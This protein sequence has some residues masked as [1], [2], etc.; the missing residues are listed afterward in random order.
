M[1]VQRQIRIDDAG[2]WIYRPER[3]LEHPVLDLEIVFILDGELKFRSG[4]RTWNLKQPDVLLFNPPLTGLQLMTAPTL[5]ISPLKEDCFFI[6]L[7]V[8]PPFLA[9]AFDGVIPVFECDSTFQEKD[10][11]VLRGI[12]AEIASGSITASQ[13]LLFYSRLYR[14]LDELGSHFTPSLSA[15]DDEDGKRRRSIQAYIGKHYHSPLGLEDL[16]AYL[17]LSPQYLSRYFKKLYGVNF[18]AYLQRFR[19][20]KALYDLAATDK[21]VAA[22]AY[23]NGFPNL[24]A[25]NRE[26]KEMLGQTPTEYR[27]KQGI[28]QVNLDRA[29]V[30]ALEIESRLVQDRL[31]PFIEKKA[32][33][34]RKTLSVD[35]RSG[36]P[37]EKPWQEVINLGFATDFEKSEFIAQ[38]A[39][40]QREAPFRYARFQGIFGKSMLVSNGTEYGFSRIDRIIDFLSSVN[41]IP[42]IEIGFKPNKITRDTAS[43]LFNNDNEMRNILID[44]FEKLFIKFLKHAITRYGVQEVNRWRFEWWVPTD[45]KNNIADEQIKDY[46]E[47]FVRIRKV[48]KNLVPAALIGG[49]GIVA[50]KIST[51]GAFG[52]I[53]RALRLK[54]S[55]PDFISFYLFGCSH[56]EEKDKP[57]LWEKDEIPKRIKWVKQCVAALHV[58]RPEIPN[59]MFFVTEW[60]IDYSSRN[61]IH[62]SLLKAPYILQNAIHSIDYVGALSYWLLSDISTEYTDSDALLFGGAGLV[63]RHDIQKPAFFAFRFLS[64]LGG[65]LILKGEGY[66]VTAKSENEFAA[67]LFNYKYLSHRSRFLEQYR[68]MKGDI[69]HYLED[70]EPCAVSLEIRN[71]SPGRYKVRQYILNSHHG[72]IYDAWLRLSTITNL[73]IGET[74]WL[75]HTCI[76]NLNIDFLNSQGSLVI[77]CELEPNEVRLLEISRILE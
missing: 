20:G 33:K 77:D 68:D 55:F 39:F 42:F 51:T 10:F 71:L 15:H 35:G 14:L 65:R 18:H 72:S 36:V 4:T 24:T 40:I 19:L 46:V 64:K 3:S 37:F 30:E 61:M 23:D 73:Q 49:P 7:R 26:M 45:K 74:E 56:V 41:L 47:S 62:D 12:L 43:F 17:S 2:V 76:P 29:E 22:V 54:N 28:K 1:S 31:A 6:L 53:L 27:R 50:E 63:S 60:N 59:N 67:I 34:K 5:K 70:T 16:A 75:E 21:S 66:I 32:A 11:S 13:K 69:S 52:E 8:S 9:N 38:I 25:F 58:G 44:D 57:I 48:L